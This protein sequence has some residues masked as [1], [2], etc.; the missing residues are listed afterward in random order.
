MLLDSGQFKEEVSQLLSTANEVYIISAYV[1]ELAIRWLFDCNPSAYSRVRVLLRGR[2]ADFLGGSSSLKACRDIIEN[3]GEVSILEN[4][5]AKVYLIDE[6]N[7]YVG[8]ANLTANGLKLFDLGNIELLV[9][10]TPP[11]RDHL[12]RLNDIWDEG[13]PLSLNILQKIECWLSANEQSNSS[14]QIVPAWWDQDIVQERIEKLLVCDFPTYNDGTIDEVVF[15]SMRSFR[16]LLKQLKNAE[17]N[18]LY[19]GALTAKLHNSLIDDPKPYRSDVKLL[20]QALITHC[21]LYAEGL[22]SIDRPR[23]SQRLRLVNAGVL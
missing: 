2:P 19:F 18:E 4:L 15:K 8:S 9:K 14:S 6:R 16:W 21:E 17:N 5:H 7:L 1:T 23:H 10:T 3:G 12:G 11:S 22:V 13:S 20:L